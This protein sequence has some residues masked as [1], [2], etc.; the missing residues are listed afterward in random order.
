LS[1]AGFW[2]ADV[3][4][5]LLLGFVCFFLTMIPLGPT[6]GSVQQLRLRLDG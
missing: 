1:A 5:A 4:G 3:P 2:A 6:L